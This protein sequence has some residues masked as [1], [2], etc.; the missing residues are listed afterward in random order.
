M[1]ETDRLTL[2]DDSGDIVSEEERAHDAFVRWQ[3]LRH[4]QFGYLANL[5]LTLTT[6][7]LG[8]GV[9]L[10]A[11]KQI[12]SD[13]GKKLLCG[14]LIIL[15]FA[16]AWGLLT[17]YS[18]LRDLR[19]AAK[20]ARKRALR[21]RAK[22]KI[23]PEQAAKFDAEYQKASASAK[24]WGSCSWALLYLQLASFSSVLQFLSF[25]SGTTREPCPSV[26]RG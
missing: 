10:F 11:D 2:A 4:T 17:S 20:A 8:F 16:V 26:P 1:N 25:V 7:A 5:V 18:R 22:K 19:E 6:A 24:R 15:L 14:S 23:E 3:S 12:S 13:L 9:K 21:A